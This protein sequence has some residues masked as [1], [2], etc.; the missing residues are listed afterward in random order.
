MR[1][2]EEK[3]R[4]RKRGEWEREREKKLR[5]GSKE[6]GERREAGGVSGGQITY[7]C[8]TCVMC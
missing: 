8:V 1:K 4:K 7:P 5:E 3:G 6:E 2:E